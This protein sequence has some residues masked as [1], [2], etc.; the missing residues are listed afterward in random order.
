MI[1]KNGDSFDYYNLHVSVE[2]IQ[3][4]RIL[5]VRIVVLPVPQEEEED[6]Q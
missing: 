5:K 1:P 4:N 3:H 2:D 6:E